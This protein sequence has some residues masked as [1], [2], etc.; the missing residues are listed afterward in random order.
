MH[1]PNPFLTT[2]NNFFGLVTAK[3]KVIL[4]QKGAVRELNPRPLAPK[5]RIIPLDQ[6]PTAGE[7]LKNMLDGSWTL[8]PQIPSLI[9]YPLRHEDLSVNDRP[10]KVCI[11]AYI[12]LRAKKRKTRDNREI[13]TPAELLPIDF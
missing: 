7:L 9:R 11:F 3:K 8:N 10:T 5:A 1:K 6:R 4:S 2:V 12:R 13:R